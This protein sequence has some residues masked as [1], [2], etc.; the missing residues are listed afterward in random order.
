M[1]FDLRKIDQDHWEV[2]N[3]AHQ[4]V[5]CGSLQRCRDWLDFQEGCQ[6]PT[7]L[8][9]VASWFKTKTRNAPLSTAP[10]PASSKSGVLG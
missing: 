9:I 4:Q 1:T 10:P 2:L 8:Q 6:Q 3:E 5:F 7:L